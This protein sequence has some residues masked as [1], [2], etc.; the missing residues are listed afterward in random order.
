MY[1]YHR[2]WEA[3]GLCLAEAHEA[4]ELGE[5]PQS[6]GAFF[7]RFRYRLE[8][9]NHTPPSPYFLP[10]AIVAEQYDPTRPFFGQL[11]L[12]DSMERCQST[13]VEVYR[14]AI[15]DKCMVTWQTFASRPRECYFPS[16]YD[17]L[18]ERHHGWWINPIH[19]AMLGGGGRDILLPSLDWRI[20]GRSPVHVPGHQVVLADRVEDV[21]AAKK[22]PHCRPDERRRD[23]VARSR[24]G[25]ARP[26]RTRPDR[27]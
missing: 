18:Y 10:T 14:Q 8:A 24:E 16:R 19:L 4:L 7:D 6:Q 9:V 27:L 22:G 25:M 15:R 3:H 2:R 20:A 13:I 21:P 5:E 23:S 26:S 12:V 11:I 1:D 17:I